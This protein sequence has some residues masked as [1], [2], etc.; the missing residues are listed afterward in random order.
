MSKIAED[1]K[2]NKTVE[3]IP[4]KEMHGIWL[5]AANMVKI[6]QDIKET[7]IPIEAA[8]LGVDA[9]SQ[10]VGLL[11]PPD[12]LKQKLRKYYANINLHLF[13]IAKLTNQRKEDIIFWIDQK[14]QT[15]PADK[16]G[17]F[18]IDKGSVER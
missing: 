9:L 5:A 18:Y 6:I 3:S 8:Y 13:E 16:L 10:V 17:K 7:N 11:R 1:T 14:D 15:N 12:M 2:A 4:D